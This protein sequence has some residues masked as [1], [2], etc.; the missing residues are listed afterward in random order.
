MSSVFN[1]YFSEVIDRQY[2]KFIV[3]ARSR[4]GSNLLISL[5]NSHPCIKAEGELFRILHG[6]NYK[7]ILSNTFPEKLDNIKAKGFKIFYYHPVDNVSCGIWEDLKS[8][9]DLFV[10]H[11]KR[12][13]ILR[14]LVS[15]KIAETNNEWLIRNDQSGI[16][17]KNI[18]SVSF[19][20]D[21]LKKWFEQT[22]RWE[23]E[24]DKNFSHHP[25]LSITYEEIVNDR[26]NAFQKIT[27][28]LG[29]HF[30]EPNTKLKRQ[31]NRT[32][33]ECIKNYDELKSAFVNTEWACFFED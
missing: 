11:L 29:V 1:S 2:R 33:R 18:L 22:R 21:E 4:T 3:L 26:V 25:L 20:V 24:S 15:K 14:T 13:N 12:N 7:K 9:D 27:E 5:L 17:Q 16:D 10:I 8:I 30:V 28:F 23:I 6:E 32:M 19:S 31:N